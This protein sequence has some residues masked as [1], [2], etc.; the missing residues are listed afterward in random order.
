MGRRARLKQAPPQPLCGSDLDRNRTQKGKRRA[1]SS[2]TERDQYKA[3]K[4]LP[5][6]AKQNNKKENPGRRPKQ[7]NPGRRPKPVDDVNEEDSELEDALQPGDLSEDEEETVKVKSV[8]KGKAKQGEEAS[9][10]DEDDDIHGP[11]KELRFSD[12]ENGG[13]DDEDEDLPTGQHLFDLDE[14]PEGEDLDDEAMGDDLNVED[15][16]EDEDEKEDSA[17]ASSNE[18]EEDVDMADA[19]DEEDGEI[20]TNLEDDLEDEGYTLPAV[21]GEAEEHEHGTSLR[22]V[23]LRMRWLVGVCVNKDERV[24]KGVPGK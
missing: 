3:V 15:E 8:K 24:S 10:D 6:K 18:G 16:D 7:E 12:E 11:A 5:S 23:E 2:K 22:E 9:D 1:P 21:D 4:G 17:F 19:G 14:V 13:A 20:T